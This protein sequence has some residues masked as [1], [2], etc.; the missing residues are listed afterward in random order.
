MELAGMASRELWVL[1][2]PH[3]QLNTGAAM[4]DEDG[5]EDEDPFRTLPGKTGKGG[6]L[7]G[8]KQNN[9]RRIS[10]TVLSSL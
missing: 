10:L 8:R 3:I 2:V 1:E 6:T 4:L 9:L 7:E 5:E